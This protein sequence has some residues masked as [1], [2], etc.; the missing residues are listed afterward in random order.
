M[1]QI[2]VSQLKM[3]RVGEPLTALQYIPSMQRRR[4]SSIAKLAL[5]SA[6]DCLQAQSVNYIVWASQYGDE[7]KTYQILSDVLNDETPSPTQFSTSVHNAVAGLYSILCQ[8][9][10]PSTSLCASWSEACMEAYAYLKI[11]HPEGK[12]L[13][14][15]YDEP[16]PDIYKEHHKFE[17]FALAATLDL[18]H[19]NITFDIEKM[20]NHYPKHQEALDF[21][22]HFHIEQ[23]SLQILNH[24]YAWQKC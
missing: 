24:D 7:L 21:Y 12:A 17:G 9:T 6:I 14:I 10:T 16:L 23:P 8:D 5:N 3:T 18:E 1:V 4:L 22:H 13:V 20:T 19:T 11:H 2:R 15:Y